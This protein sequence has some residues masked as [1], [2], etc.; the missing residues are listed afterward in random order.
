MPNGKPANVRCVQLGDHHECLLFG[1][2]DRP[3]FCEGLKPAAEMCGDSR[4]EALL[5]L[6]LMETATQP[7]RGAAK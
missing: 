3:S 7:D 5:W 4:Q 2:P 6:G 1:Q